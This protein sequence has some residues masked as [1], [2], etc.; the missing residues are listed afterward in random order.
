[1]IMNS[2]HYLDASEHFKNTADIANLD[3]AEG[4]KSFSSITMSNCSSMTGSVSTY[5][6]GG[7]QSMAV[8][9]Q[10]MTTFFRARSTPIE[11]KKVDRPKILEIDDY[12][13]FM[14]SYSKYYVDKTLWIKEVYDC[15]D[16]IQIYS[17]PRDMGKSL[18]L[19]ML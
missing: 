7:V 12:E 10:S 3:M 4:E 14:A 8:G 19:S 5:C 18:N 6:D 11:Y 2:A 15:K 16:R 13:K 9:E 17:K 1:M